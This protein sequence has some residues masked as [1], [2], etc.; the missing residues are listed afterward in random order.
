[1]ILLFLSVASTGAGDDA[2]TSGPV[3]DA[4]CRQAVVNATAFLDAGGAELEKGASCIN[5]HHAPLRRWALREAARAGIAVDLDAL[6]LATASQLEKL[7]EV[8]DDYRDKQWGHTLSAFYVLGDLGDASSSLAEDVLHELAKI[9][10]AEQ[11][12]DGSWEAAQQFGNQRRTSR[13]ADQ[14]QTMWSILALSRMEPNTEST[15]ARDRGLDWLNAGE[16]GT[17]IDARALRFVIE[18]T[19]GQPERREEVLKPLRE[20]QRPDGGWGWQPE[21]PS[22]AWPTGLALY[23]LSQAN[24]DGLRSV[25]SRGRQF[26]INTQNEDGSWLVEGKLTSSSEMA[27]YFGT[28]WAIVGLSRTL[29]AR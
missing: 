16:P 17:T 29:P 8:K 15:A 13:D 4:A 23:A 14:V 22:E 27:S 20:T 25:L 5:C 9:I 24:D 19:F 1:M 12:A 2:S 18:Q 7:A 6:Q 28:V 21:D 3:D 11:S 10:V 26:L